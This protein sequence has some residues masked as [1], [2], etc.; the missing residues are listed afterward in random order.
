MMFL[1]KIK[2]SRK[3]IFA[4]S[5]IVVIIAVIGGIGIMSLAKVNMNSRD[6]YA[7][8]LQSVYRLTDMKQQIMRAQ[9]NMVQL[10]YQRDENKKASLLKDID[11]NTNENTNDMKI[12]SGLPK[13]DNEKQYFNSFNEKLQDYR[14]IKVKFLEAINNNNYEDAA[15]YYKDID[16]KWAPMLS[17]LNNLINLNLD[18][19]K[20]ADENNK[21]VFDSASTKITAGLLLSIILSIILG[22][23]ITRQCTVPLSKIKAFARRIAN[24]DFSDPIIIIG[25]DEFAEVAKD[26]NEA[27]ENVKNLV[28]NILED[29]QN[30][31][32]S[33]EELAAMV[34]QLNASFENITS[35]SKE[36]NS[37]VQENSAASEEIMASVEE[38]DASV[39]QLSEK[40]M[41][42]SNNANEAKIR[43]TEMQKSCEESSRAITSLHREKNE[44]ILKAIEDG[45][46]VKNIG[47]MSD[48]IASIAEQIN[49][50]ALN[51]AIEAARAGEHGKGFAVVAEEV[52]KLAEQS[53]ESVKDIKD[54]I[55]KVQEAF[56]NLSDNSSDVLK[57]IDEDI[58]EQFKKFEGMVETYYKD[59]NFV[60]SVTEEIAAMT[61][62]ITATVGQVSEAIQNMVLSTET[63]SENVEKIGREMIEVTHGVEQVAS[64]TESQAQVAQNLNKVIERFK[65]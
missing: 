13:G 42:G 29:S 1:R 19:A 17:D 58:D 2:M 43:A 65:V 61:E 34:Q 16:G 38:V 25:K 14:V 47:V 56:K 6:M 46:V 37:G 59:S 40:A 62:E 36:I 45:K 33:S 21:Q 11:Q 60:S 5:I 4:F 24:Y 28:K 32:A 57:F 44:K 51:A 10:I 50:L 3:M 55:V 49:L 30:M 52:R 31:S 27:Q 41:D 22:I 18:K 48:S 15:R 39:N 9:N 12:Y 20:Q 26:L 53:S 23:V 63:S 8:N 54:T 7:N 64:T 35:S